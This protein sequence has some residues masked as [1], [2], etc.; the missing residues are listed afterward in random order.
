MSVSA[1]LTAVVIGAGL[2]AVAATGCASSTPSPAPT[3]T[4]TVTVA[5]PAPVAT[6]KPGDPDMSAAAVCGQFSALFSI[7]TNATAAAKAGT[8]TRAV[9]AAE[10]SSIVPG[11]KEAASSDSGVQSAQQ[12]LAAALSASSTSAPGLPYDPSS[13]GYRAAQQ[14]LV[15]ACR[16]AGSQISEY[17]NVGG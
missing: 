9:E 8:I 3:V 10:L 14:Q 2:L 6:I 16:A 1:R 7:E 12:K 15:S 5:T 17:V 13:T 11:M 4:K